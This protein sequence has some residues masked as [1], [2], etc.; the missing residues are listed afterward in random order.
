MSGPTVLDLTAS[1]RNEAD[2]YIKISA[3]GIDSASRADLRT[4]A[5]T[6][7]RCADE[8]AERVRGTKG[9]NQ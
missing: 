9:T 6:L 5:D 1:W 2:A 7:R 8:L 4:Q 3:L